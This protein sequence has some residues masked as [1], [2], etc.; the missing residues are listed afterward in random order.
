[1]K[2]RKNDIPNSMR[3]MEVGNKGN[4]GNTAKPRRAGGAEGTQLAKTVNQQTEE[5]L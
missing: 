3:K 5:T 4:K 2:V 1:M